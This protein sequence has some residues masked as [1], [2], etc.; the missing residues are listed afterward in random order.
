M[1]ET[2]VNYKKYF[3]LLVFA[4]L[5]LFIFF[6]VLVFRNKSATPSGNP[7]S[8]L[9]QAELS[10]VSITPLNGSTTANFY[11]PIQITFSRPVSGA[12]KSLVGVLSTPPIKGSEDWKN[13]ILLT[14]IPTVALGQNQKYTITI[15]YDRKT[16]TFSFATLSNQDAVQKQQEADQN[17]S[18]RASEI[19]KQYPWYNSVNIHTDSYFAY[20]DLNKKVFIAQLYNGPSLSQNQLN[21][22]KAEIQSKISSLG[23]NANTFPVEWQLVP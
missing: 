20:F 21:A 4:T 5:S 22:T 7:P 9:P 1:R 2:L 16:N 18:Q 13:N 10:V 19:I 17:F 6:L 23:G 3:L 12:E 14:L 15:A 11:Q 8:S